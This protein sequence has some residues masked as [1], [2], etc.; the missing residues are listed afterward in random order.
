MFIK[1]NILDI[2]ANDYNYTLKD[3]KDNS[4]PV[5]FDGE[6]THILNYEPIN[7]QNKKLLSDYVTL[8]YDFYNESEAEMKSIAML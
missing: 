8:R 1:G 3:E 5:Y 4:F 7:I 6:N 2:V